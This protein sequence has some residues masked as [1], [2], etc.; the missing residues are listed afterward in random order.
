[1]SLK[2][3]MSEEERKRISFKM[4]ELGER[5]GFPKEVKKKNNR[6]SAANNSNK[7]NRK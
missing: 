7:K 6:K 4:V 5:Y 3:S 2:V 1:M